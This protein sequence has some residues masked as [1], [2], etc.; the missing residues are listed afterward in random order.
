MNKVILMGR[1]T[2]NPEIYNADSEEKIVCKYALA[3]RRMIQ[4]E[5]EENV[6]YIGCNA[7]AGNARFAEKH[8][9]QGTKVVITGRIQTGSYTKDGVKR[10]TSTVVIETQE[11]A[12]S[13]IVEEAKQKKKEKDSSGTKQKKNKVGKG[14][15]KDENGFLQLEDGGETE[16]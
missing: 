2:R 16:S 7:F 10:Y 11:F 12:E 15:N 6:D 8:F 5:G 3:V 9:Q 13:K 4:R 1:L 14:I